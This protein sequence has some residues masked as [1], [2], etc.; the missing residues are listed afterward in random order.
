[1]AEKEELTFCSD[2]WSQTCQQM[3]SGTYRRTW[4]LCF[5]TESYL[6]SLSSRLPSFFLMSWTIFWSCLKTQH[7]K[8]ASDLNRLLTV[9]VWLFLIV[10]EFSVNAVDVNVVQRKRLRL[11]RRTAF[12]KETGKIRS[13]RIFSVAGAASL[14]NASMF[15]S[16]LRLLDVLLLFF[17]F[18]WATRPD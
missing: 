2:A 14:L 17:S 13:Y 12:V 10:F 11:W 3:F 18:I 4:R 5:I 15:L 1:M 9:L 16:N 6:L 8:S 7:R